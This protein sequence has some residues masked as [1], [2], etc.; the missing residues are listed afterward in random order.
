[1]DYFLSNSQKL[2]T[3]DLPYYKAIKI[4]KYYKYI[5]R[6][7]QSRSEERSRKNLQSSSKSK[8]ERIEKFKRG[9]VFNLILTSEVE[10]PYLF[11]VIF[12]MS[13]S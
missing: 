1:M 4:N 3:S 6:I 10:T 11:P 5:G 13:E 7:R 2:K 12:R 8:H 9:M